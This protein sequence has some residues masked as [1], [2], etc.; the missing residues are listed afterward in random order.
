MKFRK[1]N[2]LNDFLENLHEEGFGLINYQN[3]KIPCIY[4]KREI[5]D[6]LLKKTYGKKYVV[7]V[8]LNIFY[9]GKYMFVDIMLDFMNLGLEENFLMDVRNIEFFE[10][11]YQHCL[12]SIIPIQYLGNS[13]SDIFLI[14]L[15]KKDKINNALDI[16]KSNMMNIQNQQ[17]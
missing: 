17:G 7:E 4:V 10:F 12:L 13:S 15:P 11:L 5:Y 16:I 8:L 1:F 3:H 14:Q 9:N 6:N 2:E